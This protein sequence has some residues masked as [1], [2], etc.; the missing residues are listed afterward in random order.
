MRKDL[1]VWTFFLHGEARM[2]HAVLVLDK[3]GCQHQVLLAEKE[4]ESRFHERLKIRPPPGN[5]RKSMILGHKSVFTPGLIN[6][7]L[8]NPLRS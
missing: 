3:E 1:K 4:P 5:N 6:L 8:S 7:S 2:T